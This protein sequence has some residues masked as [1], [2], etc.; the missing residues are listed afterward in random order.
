MLLLC[1]KFDIQVF[2]RRNI[3]MVGV[4]IWLYVPIWQWSCW[5][6]YSFPKKNCRCLWYT[7]NVY[8]E[9][10]VTV[11]LWNFEQLFWISGLLKRNKIYESFL[12][13]Y[14]S[15][16]RFNENKVFTRVFKFYEILIKFYTCLRC[17]QL[18]IL[19]LQLILSLK[20]IRF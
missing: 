10:L 9:S 17:E 8:I 1:K 19:E 16:F 15:S 2:H 4:C 12:N 5:N 11:Q 3:D 13:P 6:S 20:K 7:C 18:F 14:L